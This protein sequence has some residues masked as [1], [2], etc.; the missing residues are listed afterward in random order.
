MHM[1]TITITIFGSDF[2]SFLTIAITITIT[3]NTINIIT[4]IINNLSE[5]VVAKVD[6]LQLVELGERVPG[7]LEQL[8]EGGVQEL[9]ALLVLHRDLR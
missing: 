8:V 6:G 2:I 5:V 9:D 7:D 1:I 3:I 4:T